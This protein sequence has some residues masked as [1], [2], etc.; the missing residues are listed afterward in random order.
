MTFYITV[1]IYNTFLSG[2]FVDL[3]PTIDLKQDLT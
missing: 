1:I 2:F 3:I